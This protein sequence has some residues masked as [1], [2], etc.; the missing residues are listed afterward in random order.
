MRLRKNPVLDALADEQIPEVE[1]TEKAYYEIEYAAQLW[2][3]ARRV[4][5]VVKPERTETGGYS[6]YYLVTNLPKAE[7][8]APIW[9]LCMGAGAR[10]RCT[11]AR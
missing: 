4:V 5:V 8:R 9:L 2:D 6:R 11:R 10:R 7:Y 3:H 1:L